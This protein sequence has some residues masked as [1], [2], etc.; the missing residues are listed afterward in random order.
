MQLT[1]QSDS[2]QRLILLRFVGFRLL[3]DAR[4]SP[5]AHILSTEYSLCGF[6]SGPC[7]RCEGGAG[8]RTRTEDPGRAGPLP[9]S[10]PW[11]Q[12]QTN[13]LCHGEDA[14]DPTRPGVSADAFGSVYQTSRPLHGAATRGRARRMPPR[15][16]TMLWSPGPG[17]W[18]TSVTMG[19]WDGWTVGRHQTAVCEQD[20]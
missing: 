5:T 7:A 13:K 15:G 9:W 14:L 16:S 3:F 20:G 19:A 4:K 11:A 12:T 17:P 8:G 6:P 10:S 18:T 2:C 1:A